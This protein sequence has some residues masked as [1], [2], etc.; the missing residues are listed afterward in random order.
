MKNYFPKASIFIIGLFSILFILD[1]I[2]LNGR[3]FEWGALTQYGISTNQ[4]WRL[5]TSSFLHT[6][7]I[8]FLANSIS[9]YFAGVII[10]KKIGSY[11]FLT[12]FLVCNLI[13]RIISGFILSFDYSI[14][15]SPG[16]YGIMGII[17]ISCLKEKE[18]F[19]EHKN[20]WEMN[21]VI[22][23][24]II[25][26]LLGLDTFYVHTVGFIVGIVLYMKGTWFVTLLPLNQH[27]RF[28]VFV[29]L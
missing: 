17:L 24:F 11:W 29:F 22:G 18:L 6:G 13:E 26:N 5:I 19:T 23:Y 12:A 20:T 10:E 7:H 14:G 3:A 21:W 25:G 28:Y 1:T 16:I 9:L 27:T 2:V 15:S 8:H 4:W